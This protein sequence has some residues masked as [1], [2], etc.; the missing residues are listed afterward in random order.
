MSLGITLQQQEAL[1][2]LGPVLPPTAYLARG[3][4]IAALE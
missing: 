3:V 2:L 1:R 4:A